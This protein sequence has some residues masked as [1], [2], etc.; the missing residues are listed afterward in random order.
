MN[1]PD[2]YER[3]TDRSLDEPTRAPDR[4]PEFEVSALAVHRDPSRP[5]QPAVAAKAEPAEKEATKRAVAWV[6]PTDL[7]T[8]MGARPVRRGIDLQA[9][10][11]RRARRAPINATARAGRRITRTAIARP[12][13]ASTTV[14]DREGL[15]L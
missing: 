15:E 10:L 2:H 3:R 5:A 14:V 8:F 11:T 4:M 1:T 7:P 12:D 13:R 9:E 6:R